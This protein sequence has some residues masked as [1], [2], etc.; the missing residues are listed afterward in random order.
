[1]DRSSLIMALLLF[2]FVCGL[3]WGFYQLW[4]VEDAKRRR[5]P[6]SLAEAHGRQGADSHPDRA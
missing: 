3:V 5:S 6:A 2:T 1:M 4:S